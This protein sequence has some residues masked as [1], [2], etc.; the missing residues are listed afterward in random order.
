VI[1]LEYSTVEFTIEQEENSKALKNQ[2][3]FL[4]SILDNDTDRFILMSCLHM[5]YNQE[6]VA[7][8]VGDM[9]QANI[10]KRLKRIRELLRIKQDK[11]IF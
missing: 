10:S 5:G 8:M 6:D 1:Q 11:V 7:M 4:Y 2:V 9:T 3:V